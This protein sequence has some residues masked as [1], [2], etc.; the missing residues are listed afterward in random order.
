MRYCRVTIDTSR[1]PS[2]H[3]WC[4]ENRKRCRRGRHLVHYVPG[5]IASAALRY[6]GLQLREKNFRLAR[7]RKPCR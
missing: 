1:E 6:R 2:V 7:E 5:V 3:W 4:A